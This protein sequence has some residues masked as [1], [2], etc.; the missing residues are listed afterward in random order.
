MKLRLGACATAVVALTAFHSFQAAADE[1]KPVDY[2]R[3]CDAYGAGFFYVPG[4]ETCIDFRGRGGAS[5]IENPSNLGVGTVRNSNG[6][7]NWEVFGS[8]QDD[9]FGRIGG[10]LSAQYLLGEYEQFAHFNVV[11]SLF[12]YLDT[13]FAGG[14]DDHR[15]NA[16]IGQGVSA[17]GFTFANWHP[18][19]GTGLI[20]T[21]PGFS[22]ISHTDTD[23]GWG[24][25]TGGIGKSYPF[26]LGDRMAALVFKTGPYV[27]FIN[28]D[29]HGRADLYFG[30]QSF[31]NYYQA[32]QYESSDV[33]AGLKTD[34]ALHWQPAKRWI[35]SA[36]GFV[37]AGYHRGE[38][39]YW[40]NT[41]VGTAP[42]PNNIVREYIGYR[43]SDFSIGGGI[44]F[45]ANYFLNPNVNLGFG[46]S[47]SILPDVTG[48]IAAQ[49]PLQQPSHF[50]SE[51]IARLFLNLNI[52][53]A[54]PVE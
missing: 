43:S 11:P 42:P 20:A 3:V 46:V 29:S 28:F 50:V 32:Y 24:V 15:G 1:P 53:V 33:Y 22:L 7:N 48:F 10:G 52:S 19:Y 17:V 47:A 25:G 39:D 45:D 4:T 13:D 16:Q 54:I 23:F 41:V 51:S 30:G 36:N 5:W 35:L 21:G 49:N 40:L 9:T 27:E 44:G 34:V 38:G 8:G 2:V 18:V 31:R 6:N 14:T 12:L 26:D 37:F